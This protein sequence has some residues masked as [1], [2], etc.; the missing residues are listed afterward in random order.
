MSHPAS[1]KAGT[2]LAIRMNP[3]NPNH[4]LW[5]NN[6]TWF[7]H[8]TVSEPGCSGE[9]RRQS[10]RTH[11]ISEARKRRNELF[12]QNRATLEQAS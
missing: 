3:A 4:H 12:R 11:K 7:V 6:G 9:R 10:L 2:S 5:N 1:S 8:Y